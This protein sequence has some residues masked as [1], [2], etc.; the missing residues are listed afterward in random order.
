M[1]IKVKFK[2]NN[3]F[4]EKTFKNMLNHSYAMI[5][6]ARYFISLSNKKDYSDIFVINYKVKND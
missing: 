4:K 2:Q 5:F 1:T 6:I 3:K